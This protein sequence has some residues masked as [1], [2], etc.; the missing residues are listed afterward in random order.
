MAQ[1]QSQNENPLT[2]I[3]QFITPNILEV[4]IYALIGGFLL[5]VFNARDIWESLQAS[6]A[7]TDDTTQLAASSNGGFWDRIANSPLPQLVFWAVIGAAVYALVWFAW[8]IINNFRNDMA[9]NSFVHP[10]HYNKSKYWES[11][12]IRKAVFALCA[13][14]LVVYL[15]IFFNLVATI[16]DLA[17]SAGQQLA[18]PQGLV[19]M[20][21]YLLLATILVYVLVLIY[22]LSARAWGTIYKDL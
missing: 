7:I 20:G 9:A 10:K 21:I 15:V 19:E 16:S 18:L 4:I 22:R 2:Q 5:V 3:R 6:L 12:L 1:I 8:N 17:Y 13:V 14:V 11:V